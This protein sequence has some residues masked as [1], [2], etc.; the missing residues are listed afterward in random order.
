MSV[1]D[2]TPQNTSIQQV[3]K[4][5]L[6][7][8][9]IPN[10]VFYCQTVNIPG[11]TLNSLSRETALLNLKIPGNKLVYDKLQLEFLVDE[12]FKAWTELYNWFKSIA[13]PKT[14]TDRNQL[15][16]LQKQID[17]NQKGYT[18]YSDATLTI[19][20]NLNNPQNRIVFTDIFPI[21]LS[22]LNFDTKQGADSVLTASVTFDYSYFDITTA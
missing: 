22:S 2:R 11:I 12:D 21:A 1:L 18:Y 6:T 15:T 10:V 9:K 4:Y 13:A 17:V 7:I 16:G 14:F 19:L 5:I 20:S 3:S 8:K